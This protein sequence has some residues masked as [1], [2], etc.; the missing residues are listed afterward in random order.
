[1]EELTQSIRNQRRPKGYISSLDI[2]LVHPRTPWVIAWWA[3]AFPGF[4]HLLLGMYLKGFILIVWEIF[5]NVNSNLNLA[6]LYSFT[7]QFDLA[8]NTLNKKWLLLYAPVYIA[9]IWDSYRL[10]V[11][12]NK[13]S[14]LADR[15]KS[16]IIPF[17]I[18]PIA[19]NFFDKRN[20]WI[21]TA[22]SALIPGLGQICT[23]RCFIGFFLLTWWIA[24]AYFSNLLEAIHFTSV[25]AF[26]QAV[27]VANPG[28]MIF[29][30]SI[31]GLA[32]FDAYV[33]AVEY[34]KLFETEQ[35][36]FLKDNYQ[37]SEFVMPA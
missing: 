4:G 28:W 10:T 14:I 22:W 2:N 8:I 37:S 23:N 34:N 1:M 19:M 29:L 11:D 35:A 27:S 32:V 31:Y 9:S 3:A 13:Y 5:T 30:P 26:S 33:G 36:R 15:E 18:S 24:I 21:T 6:I 17:K 12:L 7:G 25:G 20:P 16:P